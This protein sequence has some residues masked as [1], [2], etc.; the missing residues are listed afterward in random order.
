MPNTRAQCYAEIR[1]AMKN[2]IRAYYEE[3]P[4]RIGD[5]RSNDAIKHSMKGLAA[6]FEV[7]DKYDIQKKKDPGK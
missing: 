1:T 7:L 6:I 4:E 5:V 2:G 3:F